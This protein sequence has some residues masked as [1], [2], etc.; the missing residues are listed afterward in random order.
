MPQIWYNS[1]EVADFHPHVENALKNALSICGYDPIAEVVHHPS[2]PNSTIIPDFAVRLKAS[3]TYVL[4]CEVKRS[5]RDVDS[6]RYQNQ[7]RAYVTDFGVHWALGYHKYFCITNI[8]RLV[9]LADRNGPLATCQLKGNPRQHS[10]FNPINHDATAALAGLQMSFVNM[11]PEI[12]NRIAPNWENNWAHIIENFHSNYLALKSQLTYSEA[13]SKELT[14]YELFRLL[15]YSYL[16]DYYHQTGNGNA[17]HFKNYPPA[18]ATLRQFKNSLANN[19]DRI[20]QLDFKQI[21]INHPNQALRIFPENFSANYLQHFRDLIHCFS[22]YSRDAVADNSSPSYVFNLLTSKIYDKDELHKKGKVMSDSELSSLLA[23]LCVETASSTVLDPGSGDGA[24]LDAAYDQLN[25]ISQSTQVPKTHNQLLTQVYGIEIDPFLSQLSAFRLLSKNLTQIDNTTVANVLIGDIFNI[26]K[27]NQ[28]DVVLMNPPFVRNDNPDAPSKANKGQ[29][30]SAIINTGVTEFVTKAKQPNLYFYFVNYLWHYLKIDGKAG[31]ILMT[32]FLNN[33]DGEYLKEFITDKVEAIISYPRK[34]FQE[35]V[36]STVIVVLKNGSNTNGVSFLRISDESVLLNPDSVKTILRSNKSTNTASYKLKVI[37]RNILHPSDNWKQY[38]QDQKYD[39]FLGLD[40]LKNIE[41]HFDNVSRGG[42]ES[43]GLS[44]IIYPSFDPVTNQY[45]GL[46]IKPSPGQISNGIQRTKIFIPTALT[47][48]IGLGVQNNFTRRSYE[49]SIG[50]LRLDSAFHFP[51]KPD[52]LSG[53][54]LTTS[55]LADIALNQFYNNCIAEFGLK[56][57]KQ[58]INNAYNN[59]FVPKILIPRADRTKHVVYYNPHKHDLTLSTNFFY[60]NGLKNYDKNKNE[61][62]QYK[63]VAAFLLS[64]FG[65]IQFELNANNQEGLRKLEGFQ[66]KRFKII[67]LESIS[68][69]EIL[70]VN[71]ELDQLNIANVEFSGDEGLNTPRRQLDIAIGGIV[72]S[73][74]TL[75]FNSV[76]D[77]VNYFELFLADL[78]EDRRI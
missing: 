68:L 59:T 31:I 10:K 73:K 15:A 22:Q 36:V 54:A 26:Q 9:L 17:A 28:F 23:A 35:F 43:S 56:K 45:F 25:F 76:I 39:D 16:K 50:D 42:S 33:E 18:T 70:K 52:K 37:P 3:R 21:F 62:S 7:T 20:I 48:R 41:H 24:L 6:Q 69:K 53:N 13:I 71:N 8:E 19:Y 78:V 30:I 29:M 5:E 34:Y 47:S 51:S 55:Q 49:L 12:F 63:F 65:Q 66:I 4:I 74:N 64:A 46:G 38:L 75:G 2:I 27:P 61:E 44:T 57:W 1:D 32:K 77:M 60:C 11:L 72:Y 67:D 58:V 14:L 40:F